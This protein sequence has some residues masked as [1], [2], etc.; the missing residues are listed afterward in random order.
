LT[1]DP[2]TQDD[3]ETKKSWQNDDDYVM[4]ALVLGV[5]P[6]LRMSLEHHTASKEI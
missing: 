3:E 4:G 5:D 2:H 6:S 1:D